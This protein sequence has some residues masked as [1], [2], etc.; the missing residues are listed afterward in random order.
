MKCVKK[1]FRVI[2]NSLNIITAYS[3]Y[4]ISLI[5]FKFFTAKILNPYKD[6]YLSTSN[7]SGNQTA[8]NNT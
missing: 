7:T 1:V 5:N 4:T 8:G 3:Y 2:I 6:K